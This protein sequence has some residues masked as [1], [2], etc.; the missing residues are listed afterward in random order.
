MPLAA[1]SD[2]SSFAGRRA[3][4]KSIR[5][6]LIAL[7]GLAAATG[8]LALAIW[9]SLAGGP[10]FYQAA[11]DRDEATS[12]RDSDKCLAQAAALVSRL[13]S[14]GEWQAIFTADQINGWLAVDLARNYGEAIPPEIANP[15]IDFH[16]GAATL[17]C[18]YRHRGHETVMSI[19][20]DLYLSQEN[21]VAL[22]LRRVRAGL[23]PVPLAEVLRTIAQAGR[24]FGLLVQ[25]Q[26]VGGDPVALIR[27]SRDVD[28]ETELRLEAVELREGEIYVA[29]RTL[30]YSPAELARRERQTQLDGDSSAAGTED[31]AEANGPAT[32]DS[33][34][35]E[36]PAGDSAQ[37]DAA[38]DA[39]RSASQV[40]SAAKENRQRRAPRPTGPERPAHAAGCLQG[41]GRSIRSG[42]LLDPPPR[43]ACARTSRHPDAGPLR[44]RPKWGLRKSDIRLDGRPAARPRPG[45][46]HRAPDRGPRSAGPREFPA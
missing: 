36:P 22:R 26:H 15:R 13:Q 16:E 24:N 2:N 33:A 18:T 19:A 8:L 25:W 17:A 44:G 6:T 12:E 23:L 10:A 20:F 21:V 9:L 34:A 14:A 31:N 1:D 37:V 38:D 32:D 28:D 4:P 5:F 11:I 3:V 30:P 42:R 29:G 35:V 40:G 46:R 27:L 43:P 41:A 7:A 39:P 45:Q